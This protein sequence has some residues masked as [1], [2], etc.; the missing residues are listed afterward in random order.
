VWPIPSS[1][2]EKIHRAPVLRVA[3]VTNTLVR[4]GFYQALNLELPVLAGG[5]EMA[6]TVVFD[7]FANLFASV[8]I[9][10]ALDRVFN[11]GVGIDQRRRRMEARRL[12]RRS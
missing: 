4:L 7:P 5:R 9:Y 3:R 11:K 10:I 12:R 2:T 8:L 1:H 6:A